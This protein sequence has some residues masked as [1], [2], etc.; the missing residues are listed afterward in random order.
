[1]AKV[2]DEH[3]EDFSSC[4]QKSMYPPGI[5]AGPVLVAEVNWKPA[6]SK[7]TILQEAQRLVHGDRGEAYGHPHE[8][9]SRTGRMWAAILGVPHVS[10][11]QVGLCMAAMKISRQCNKP[12]RDNMTD[13]AGYA[14]TVQMCVEFLELK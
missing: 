12:K 13:L 9:F 14:E 4:A 1:M 3:A 11:V 5:A 8:D 2:V 7:E 10:A 6:D